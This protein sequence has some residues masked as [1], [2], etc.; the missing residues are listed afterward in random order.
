MV[1][2]LRGS[3]LTPSVA[4]AV[5]VVVVAVAVAVADEAALLRKPGNSL[6]PAASEAPPVPSKETHL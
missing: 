6:V 3:Y 5:V 4:A 2:F 1:T